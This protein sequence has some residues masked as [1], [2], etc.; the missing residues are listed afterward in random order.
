MILD[1]I[2]RPT[3]DDHARSWGISHAVAEQRNKAKGSHDPAGR[4]DWQGEPG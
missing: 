1:P 3:F 4:H 2:C